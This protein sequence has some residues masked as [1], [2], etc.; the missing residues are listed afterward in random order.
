RFHRELARGSLSGPVNLQVEELETTVG[1]LE[2]RI[3]MME[4][5][6]ETLAS[7]M[8]SAA[9][10]K[11]QSIEGEGTVH[12]QLV[13][14]VDQMRQMLTQASQSEEQ[15]QK[16]MALTNFETLYTQAMK[17]QVQ[18][19]NLRLSHL[20]R[21]R[22]IMMIKRQ[23][24]L[25]EVNNLLLQADIS[26]RETELYQFHEAKR[27]SSLKR[28]N[29][30]S[31][32]ERHRPHTQ[33]S[34]GAPHTQADQQSITGKSG[35]QQEA[36]LSSKEKPEINI[37]QMT[38]NWVLACDAS[39]STSAPASPLYVTSV[40]KSTAVSSPVAKPVLYPGAAAELS[41]DHVE[42][43]LFVSPAVTRR[44]HQRRPAAASRLQ[45]QNSRTDISGYESKETLQLP[46]LVVHVSPG[47]DSHQETC[48]HQLEEA[49]VETATTTLCPLRPLVARAGL[50]S[51]AAPTTILTRSLTPHMSTVCDSVPLH[52]EIE[53]LKQL[54][55]KVEKGPPTLKRSEGEGLSA[56]PSP[57][58]VL[59]P[60]SSTEVPTPTIPKQQGLDPTNPVLA[61]PVVDN[62]NSV[63]PS[64]MGCTESL[65]ILEQ[66]DIEPGTF[67]GD[68]SGA[69]VAEITHSLPPTSDHTKSG[70][71]PPRSPV[72]KHI[73]Q[74]QREEKD[75][76]LKDYRAISPQGSPIAARGKPPLPRHVGGVAKQSVIN[77]SASDKGPRSKSVSD[78]E[79]RMSDCKMA[80]P[81]QEVMNRFEKRATVCDSEDHPIELRKTPSPTLHLPRVGLISRVR[82]LKP[83]AELLEESQRYR[84]GHSI[85]ATRILNKYL[86]TDQHRLDA[87]HSNLQGSCSYV[88]AT[89]HRLSCETTPVQSRES[90]RKNSDA[91]VKPNYSPQAE[92][93]FVGKLSSLG[94]KEPRHE[95][96]SDG[97]QLLTGCSRVSQERTLTDSDIDRQ[98][99]LSSRSATKAY[100]RRSCEVAIVLSS[101]PTPVSETSD[102]TRT[103]RSADVSAQSIETP[104]SSIKPSSHQSLPTITHGLEPV[105]SGDE[106]ARARAATYCVSDIARSENTRLS[107]VSS[108]QRS[109][110]TGSEEPSTS[111]DTGG[112]KST[113]KAHPSNLPS[114]EP[115]GRRRYKMGTVGVLCKQSI[116]FDLGV[117]MYSQTDEAKESPARYRQAHSWDPSHTASS[118]AENQKDTSA[119][120]PAT[121]TS[122]EETTAEQRPMS[123][124]SERELAPS[125]PGCVEKKRSRRFLRS[126]WLQKSKQ[127]FKASK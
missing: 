117:S 56:A 122:S 118:A 13:E 106:A 51:T 79:Q 7:S 92:S 105:P 80:K 63:A 43:H 41:T 52:L 123:T 115:T 3:H 19:N 36:R 127:F 11:W 111:I 102:E 67:R 40:G 15:S 93:G 27:F 77:S 110:Q 44:D 45:N 66:T 86:P 99:D 61:A 94:Q 58:K 24:L 38:E 89:D 2:D 120:S 85:Y 81:L 98:R 29:T 70:S 57:G 54:K 26:R 64:V 104:G 83:A 47:T 112:T 87:S 125:S 82:R 48:A 4:N 25:Q 108:S 76:A 95:T 91:E 23:L 60:L 101:V 30:F 42:T 59:P 113:E 72:N 90:S 100:N 114:P 10:G 16:T 103:H 21:N 6:G 74:G 5:L 119:L 50:P 73:L 46:T 32:A 34:H 97:T 22:E 65:H 116:S 53:Q 69:Q 33:V 14:L 71:I 109:Q 88:Q 107:S 75:T 8:E 126:T 9:I 37:P 35:Q 31:G 84:S 62:D 20:E 68:S 124:S 12:T 78:V 1:D 49:A 28:W 18:M 55:R 96:A 121:S 17:L 39:S